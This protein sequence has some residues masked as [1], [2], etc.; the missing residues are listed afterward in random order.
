[1]DSTSGFLNLIC[2]EAINSIFVAKQIKPTDR[3]IVMLASEAFFM[4]VP[5]GKEQYLNIC[6]LRA[7]ETGKYLIKASNDGISALIDD[8]GNVVRRC[9]SIAYQLIVSDVPG[10]SRYTFFSRCGDLIGECAI[11]IML[12]L[13][14][15]ALFRRLIQPRFANVARR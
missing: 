1:M 10:N 7:I 12:I 11:L 15:L 13:V 9:S 5:A 6:R 4:G 2:Y 8:K 3:F 14:L